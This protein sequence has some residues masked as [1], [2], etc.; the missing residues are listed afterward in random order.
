MV[1]IM[2]QD[3]MTGASTR[4]RRLLVQS[5]LTLYVQ[6]YSDFFTSTRWR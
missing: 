4:F 1:P 2:T 5:V 6:L 3:G